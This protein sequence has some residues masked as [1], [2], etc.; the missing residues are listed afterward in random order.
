MRKSQKMSEDH[1]NK[2]RIA[3]TGKKKSKEHNENNRLSHLGH[4]VSEAT[5][6]KKS[7]MQMGSGNPNYRGG[8]YPQSK[9]Q[10]NRFK[11]TVAK[12]VLKRDNYTCQLCGSKDDLH[13]DHIQ[14]WAE[15]VELR[16]EMNN[17]RT[18]CMKCH[19]QVT[20]GRPMPVNR[21]WGLRKAFVKE[22]RIN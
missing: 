14:S 16:F 15:Y 12:E 21:V 11:K 3:L 9:L 2:I 1:K 20:W 8:F 6:K 22:R 17:C 10:R 18:L 7:L 19:Y 4:K 13:V 5:K